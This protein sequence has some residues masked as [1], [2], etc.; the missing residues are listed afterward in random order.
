MKN[1]YKLVPV[2]LLFQASFALAD[3][4]FECRFDVQGGFVRL[5]IH[6]KSPDVF[7]KDYQAISMRPMGV[8]KTYP[9]EVI[10]NSRKAATFRIILGD[11][12]D[13]VLD[14]NGTVAYARIRD[15][16]LGLGRCVPVAIP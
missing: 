7:P 11:G 13:G 5:N 9:I 8:P 14:L 16:H 15:A 1:L 6:S 4:T 10:Q 2:A 3:R 12:I